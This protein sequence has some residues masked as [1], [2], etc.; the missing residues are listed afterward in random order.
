MDIHGAQR[1]VWDEKRQTFIR[2]EDQKPIP[3]YVGSVFDIGMRTSAE[4][5]SNLMALMDVPQGVMSI[6]GG[7]VL[8]VVNGPIAYP[9][10][11]EWQLMHGIG[12][13]IFDQEPAQGATTF[14]T[15][16]DLKNREG[17][18]FQWGGLQA[19]SYL[20]RARIIGTGGVKVRCGVY[21]KATPG[22][23]ANVAGI[24]VGTMIG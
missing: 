14:K 16:E 6:Y 5:F 7:S 12:S 22:L 18:L 17:L 21:P 3:S 10:Q 19:D 8:E 11:I 20:L 4:G 9:F 24:T 13:C 1:L 23:Q 15:A 2:V